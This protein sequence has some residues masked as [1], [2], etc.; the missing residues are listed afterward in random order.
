MIDEASN[1]IGGTTAAAANVISADGGDA[2][3]LGDVF[4]SGNLIEGNF[5]GSDV[6]GTKD[7]GNGGHGVY[8]QVSS[9][10]MG[11]TVSGAGNSIAFDHLAG[12]AVVDSFN[13][14]TTGIEILSNSIFANHRLGIDLGTA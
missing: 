10:R 1:T 11:G 7:L 2:I 5:I 14:P 3:A 4:A 6:T 13:G 9:N 8:T 12:V